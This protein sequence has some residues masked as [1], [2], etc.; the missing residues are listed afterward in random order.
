MK[1]KTWQ[2]MVNKVQGRGIGQK[3]TMAPEVHAK[4]RLS[5]SQRTAD[6]LSEFQV[7]MNPLSASAIDKGAEGRRRH[8]R[9]W[10]GDRHMQSKAHLKIKYHAIWYL[11]S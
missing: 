6:T 2:A 4:E 10:K 7:I 9:G 5:A 11:A 3:E 1:A 8:L